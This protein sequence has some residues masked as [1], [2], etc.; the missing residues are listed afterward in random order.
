[1]VGQRQPHAARFKHLV[2]DAE[3][4]AHAADAEVIHRLIHG[5]LHLHGREARVERAHQLDAEFV[6]ALAAEQCREDREIARLWVERG[7]GVLRHFDVREVQHALGETRV[8]AAQI[9]I[10]I[11][12]DEPDF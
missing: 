5:F 3:E 6:G 9:V 2:R 12:H 11:R 1:M 4:R 7:V 10:L 8:G